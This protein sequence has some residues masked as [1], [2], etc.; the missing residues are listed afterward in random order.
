V[1]V[2]GM[3]DARDSTALGELLSVL[4]WR[5]GAACFPSLTP[6]Y[7]FWASN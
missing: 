6:R 1:R 3:V 2:A 5:D 7:S 4:G